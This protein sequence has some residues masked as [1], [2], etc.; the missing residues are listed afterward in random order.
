VCVCVYALTCMVECHGTWV[1]ARGRLGDKSLFYSLFSPS[2]I[3]TLRLVST[4]PLSVS[5]TLSTYPSLK[6]ILFLWFDCFSLVYDFL[7]V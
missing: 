4:R 2:T 6:P 3:D 5:S 7:N 1:K